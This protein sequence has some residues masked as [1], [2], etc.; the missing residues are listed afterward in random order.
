MSV[1]VVDAYVELTLKCG[2]VC[3]ID[4]EDLKVV[5]QYHWHVDDAGYARTNIWRDGR[6]QSAPRMHRLVLGDVDA[7]LH[8]D[9]ING[10]KLDNRKSNLRICTASENAR[11]RGKQRNNTSGYKGVCYDKVRRKWK[12]EIK[13]NGVRHYLGRFDTVEDAHQAYVDAAK[14]LHGSFANMN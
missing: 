12:A 3:L 9:H 6:K 5:S 2:H 4:K 13:A 7:K 1:E 11:N 14:E 10:N 8:I